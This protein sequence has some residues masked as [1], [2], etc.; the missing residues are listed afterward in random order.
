MRITSV[1]IFLKW[2]ARVSAGSRVPCSTARPPSASPSISL[3]A[4][5]WETGFV[6]SFRRK[7]SAD[8]VFWWE[9]QSLTEPRT[10]DFPALVTCPKRSTR[11][12]L[13]FLP[14]PISFLAH[15]DAHRR[16]NFRPRQQSRG[17]ASGRGPGPVG[18]DYP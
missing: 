17:I 8:V 5:G 2:T 14:A 11:F 4:G 7:L 6:M 9:R 3:A 10:A 12:S 18:A 13:R 1:L 15:D 16:G